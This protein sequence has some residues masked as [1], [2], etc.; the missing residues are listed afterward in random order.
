MVF[1]DYNKNVWEHG[2]IAGLF[3]CSLQFAGP[4][5]L[6]F[7]FYWPFSK[8]SIVSKEIEESNDNPK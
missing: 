2:I 3:L 7:I 4:A 5:I 8:K 1:C 6:V